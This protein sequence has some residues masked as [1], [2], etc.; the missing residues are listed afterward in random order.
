MKLLPV[1]L[2]VT[3]QHNT[4]KL[5]EFLQS[6]LQL[7]CYPMEMLLVDLGGRE[8]TRLL[9][10]QFQQNV[11]FP[12]K[13]VTFS[14]TTGVFNHDHTVG[15]QCEF[16]ALADADCTL[17]PHWLR[18]IT[19]PLE[20]SGVDLVFGRYIPEINTSWQQCAAGLTSSQ[21]PYFAR[22]LPSGRL[23]AF[24][25]TVWEDTGCLFWL[26]SGEESYFRLALQENGYTCVLAPEAI[27]YCEQHGSPLRL[28]KNF[29][30]QSRIYGRLRLFKRTY[31]LVVSGWTAVVTFLAWTVTHG[32]YYLSAGCAVLLLA[33]SL[34]IARRRIP[35]NPWPACWWAPV[36]IATCKTAQAAGYACGL[37]ESF[38]GKR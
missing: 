25:R 3:V 2:M 11:P 34:L 37:L 8:D 14:G 5:E 29:W 4:Q 24:T 32:Q 18:E 38:L 26:K 36:V 15:Q 19:A 12:V 20:I 21:G 9:T 23:V 7:T 10:E 27:V 13:L 33:V 16:I 1:S 35:V 28:W 17:D 22:F 31:G 6:V 30:Q